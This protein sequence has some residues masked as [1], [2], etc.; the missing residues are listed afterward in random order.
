MKVR[1][2]E[3]FLPQSAATPLPPP[4]PL[5]RLSASVETSRTPGFTTCEWG[6]IPPQT[7]AQTLACKFPILR[8]Q[9]RGRASEYFSMASLSG[10]KVGAG[11]GHSGGVR[12][13]GLLVGVKSQKEK[14]PGKELS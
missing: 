4:H 8:P 14:K 11:H 7:P 9:S 2:D 3:A 6:G 5:L 12:I 1:Q 13:Q 10:E